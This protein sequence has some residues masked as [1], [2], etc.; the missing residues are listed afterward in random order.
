MAT[1][2]SEMQSPVMAMP[3]MD[4]EAFLK[5]AKYPLVKHSDMVE[6]VRLE[7]VEMVITAIEKHGTNYELG[8]RNI[9][10]I[11]DKKFGGPWH[12]VIGEYFAFHITHEVKTFLYMFA[13]GCHAIILWKG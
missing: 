12:C 7:A 10:D 4:R 2:S 1:S 6:E 11:M 3:T 5:M 9:K 13:S 8:A